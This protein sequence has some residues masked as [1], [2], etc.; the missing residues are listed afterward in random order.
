MVSSN[1]SQ[2]TVVQS[3]NS[4]QSVIIAGSRGFYDDISLVADPVE[5]V[6]D[7]VAETGWA[8]DEVVSGTANG[9]DTA[10]EQW[11]E[12]VGLPVNQFPADW[13]EHGKAAGPIRNEEMAEYADKAVVLWD[14]ESRG[15]EHMIETA[16][17]VMGDENVHVHR[18]RE[19]DPSPSD[20]GDDDDDG[21]AG[22]PDDADDVDYD[23]V[24]TFKLPTVL[25]A[26]V[27]GVRSYRLE[28]DLDVTSIRDV[29]EMSIDE[30]T[31]ISSI[32][33]HTAKRI[34]GSAAGHVKR[35]EREMR[36]EVL[37]LRKDVDANAS[38]P[39]RVAVV[40]GNDAKALAY[41]EVV[42]LVGDAISQSGI[43]VHEGQTVG[44]VGDWSQ[45]E[46]FGEAGGRAVRD[47]VDKKQ[48]TDTLL[49]TPVQFITPWEKYAMALDTDEMQPYWQTWG[50]DEAPREEPTKLSD[51][52]FDTPRGWEDVSPGMAP[53]ERTRRMVEWAQRVVIVAD[54]EY[55]DRMRYECR[56]QDVRCDTVFDITEHGDDVDVTRWTPDEREAYE[57]SESDSIVGRAGTKLEFTGDYADDGKPIFE[58]VQ[59]DEESWDESK[60]WREGSSMELE[61]DDY[62]SMKPND[63]DEDRPDPET[64]GGG[65]GRH[66]DRHG[67]FSE[68]SLSN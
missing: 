50:Y 36:E 61:S 5:Y 3:S 54:G 24:S 53:K 27:G 11:A 48:A 39:G 58:E 63:R 67:E 8:V 14:G 16:R 6:G 18:Y 21:D 46:A 57:P 29:Y 68:R 33:E 56:R 55:M 23:E 9:A 7:V 62:F 47:W 60:Q 1:S 31:Q 2:S 10:G 4:S 66:S 26:E 45:R 44:L 12:T 38:E 28:R 20:G 37:A 32:G 51:I 34:A 13:D 59:V 30:L 65:V 64:G 35:E 52:P 22:H 43:T 25:L 19:D 15:S 42:S 41:E 17:D 40:I 49:D